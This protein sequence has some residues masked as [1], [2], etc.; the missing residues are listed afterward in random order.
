MGITCRYRL[1]PAAVIHQTAG[2]L[3]HGPVSVENHQLLRTNDESRL[4]CGRLDVPGLLGINEHSASPVGSH[5]SLNQLAR[6]D[7][8]AGIVAIRA[9]ILNGH[10]RH[11]LHERPLSA[12]RIRKT[13]LDP[14][15]I[16]F[17][18]TPADLDLDSQ[19]SPPPWPDAWSASHRMSAA[20]TPAL[21]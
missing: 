7:S 10:D 1:S 6:D 4:A 13:A 2:R 14:A 16:R 12:I 3:L 20:H 17:I 5:L 9:E 19:Q 21:Q 8:T 18:Y 11:L 15:R